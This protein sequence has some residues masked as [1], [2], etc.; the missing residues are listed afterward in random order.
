MINQ[1]FWVMLLVMAIG[2]IP[3]STY[4]EE[5]DGSEEEIE[6]KEITKIYTLKK[7]TDKKNKCED[8]SKEKICGTCA[9]AGKKAVEEI[10]G[11]TSVEID[12]IK[13]T[14]VMEETV[15][16]SAVKKA[17]SKAGFTVKTYKEKKKSKKNEG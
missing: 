5:K 3:L 12:G 11:V 7:K 1:K 2:I 4:S 15:K 9:A 13:I 17:L 10:E 14:I 16:A 8:C 6:K